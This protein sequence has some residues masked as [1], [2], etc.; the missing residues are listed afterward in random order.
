MSIVNDDFRMLINILS[1]YIN[2]AYDKLFPSAIVQVI[3]TMEQIASVNPKASI[4][5]LILSILRNVYPGSINNETT[6]SILRE[7]CSAADL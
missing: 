5:L 1:D 2:A 6:V 3:W 4:D 7:I